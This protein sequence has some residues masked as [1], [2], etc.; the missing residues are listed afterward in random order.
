LRRDI[1]SYK[2]ATGIVAYNMTN[3]YM[4]RAVLEANKNVLKGLICSILHLNDADITSVEIKNP[5]KLGEAVDDKEF[6][7]DINK[8]TY[9]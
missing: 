9:E 8:R 2:D 4:F 1:T 5:I 6:I 3:D 7:L